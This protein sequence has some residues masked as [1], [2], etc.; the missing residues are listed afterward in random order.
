MTKAETANSRGAAFTTPSRGLATLTLIALVTS[1][2]LS[3]SDGNDSSDTEETGVSSACETT[4]IH[5]TLADELSSNHLELPLCFNETGLQLEAGPYLT[6][7]NYSDGQL[8][9]TTTAVDRP[10]ESVV[11][12]LDAHGQPGLRLNI[13]ITNLSGQ[14]AENQAEHVTSREEKLLGLEEDHALY[15]YV[16]EIAYLSEEI[17]WPEKQQALQAWAPGDEDSHLTLEQQLEEVGQTLAAYRAGE[18]GENKLYAVL[19]DLQSPLA[20]H[21]T[22]GSDMLATLSSTLTVSVPDVSQGTL[23]YREQTEQVSRRLG[24]PDYGSFEE[25]DWEFH[26]PF[27]FISAVLEREGVI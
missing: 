24:N 22:Y 14:A 17:S 9:F 2:C 15:R 8:S 4:E 10:R 12:L 20:Q 21:G 6:E 16:L 25:N 23:S 5:N 7:V 26:S 11:E 19:E 3:D 13:A 27:R 1:G 18:V